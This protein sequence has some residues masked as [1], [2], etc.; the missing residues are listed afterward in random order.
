MR[1]RKSDHKGAQSHRI[2]CRM[3]ALG[4][5]TNLTT[6]TPILPDQRKSAGCFS[7]PPGESRSGALEASR[8]VTGAHGWPASP[9]PERRCRL[10]RDV[11]HT[12]SRGCGYAD[13]S[14]RGSRPPIRTGSPTAGQQF[15]ALHRWPR[16][17][18]KLT[19]R[20][21]GGCAESRHDSKGND[22]ERCSPAPLGRRA[23]L[24]RCPGA[25]GNEPVPGICNGFSLWDPR[26]PTGRGQRS[27]SSTPGTASVPRRSEPETC[28]WRRV[29]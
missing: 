2:D 5:T 26:S 16:R 23:G 10:A 12:S 15:G 27:A 8:F 13:A 28:V 11:P 20:L 9:G 4:P 25:S 17:S 3:S 19:P 18:T 21:M 14:I 7:Y 1:G 29:S 24:R 22:H 6:T